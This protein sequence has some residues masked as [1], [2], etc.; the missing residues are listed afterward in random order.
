[1]AYGN[2][3]TRLQEIPAKLPTAENWLSFGY[4]FMDPD[5]LS[6]LNVRHMVSM[7][8]VASQVE[9]KATGMVNT[10]QGIRF[11]TRP[12]ESFVADVFLAL[13]SVRPVR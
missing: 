11:V 6:L 5:G 9:A 4:V 1:M 2:G 3:E 7:A 8:P 10:V 12:W 13:G